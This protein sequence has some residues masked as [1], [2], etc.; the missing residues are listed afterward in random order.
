[1]QKQTVE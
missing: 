1:M